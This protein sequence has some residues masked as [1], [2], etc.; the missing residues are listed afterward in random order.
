MVWY[1]ERERAE[2]NSN[3]KTNNIMNLK[4]ALVACSIAVLM[5]LGTNSVMAQGQGRGGRGNFDP[6][7]MKARQLEQTK[8]DLEITDATEWN[9]IS[10]K[11][12]AV[13]D[14]RQALMAN[15]MR[16]MFGRGGNRQRGGGEG[17][18]NNSQR[19]GRPSP[20]GEPSA[21]IQAL[22]KAITDKAP[23]AEVKAKLKAVQDENK[24]RMAKFQSAQ[25]DLRG[26]LTPRQ[27]A[28]ATLHGLLQ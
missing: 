4:R 13:M 14:A 28:I 27:E 19:Q 5:A 10:P 25:E 8:T 20:F 16:G 7:E 2:P 3:N 6:A 17:D 24:D 26:V 23:T 9:A 22:E 21:A 15:G 1:A 18:T 11:V 12:S